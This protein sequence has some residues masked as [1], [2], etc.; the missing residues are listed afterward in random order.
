MDKKAATSEPSAPVE[1]RCDVALEPCVKGDTEFEHDVCT[2]HPQI[3]WD[4]H[5]TCGTF[6][7]QEGDHD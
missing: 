4:G 6:N 7:K 5:V 3:A 1:Q 2:T